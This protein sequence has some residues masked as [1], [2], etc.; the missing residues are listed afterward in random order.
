LA[1][2]VVGS[3]GEVF[4]EWKLK[5]NQGVVSIR[6]LIIIS[7]PVSASVA[8]NRVPATNFSAL[9]SARIIRQPNFSLIYCA[10][11]PDKSDIRL[12]RKGILYR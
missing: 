8:F 6:Q 11:T 9:N 12:K 3:G 10:I 7:L 2:A 5:G 4:A 1:Y